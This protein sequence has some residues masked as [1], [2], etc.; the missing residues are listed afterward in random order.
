M[1][2][3]ITLIALLALIGSARA[4]QAPPAPQPP[5]AEPIVVPKG[6]VMQGIDLEAFLEMY[7]DL[8]GKTIITAQNLPKVTFSFRT[9]NDFTKREA[10]TF[11]ETLLSTRGI[12]IVPMNS[13]VVHA[14]PSSEVTKTPPAISVLRP[15]E[16]PEGDVYIH[17]V[18][19]LKHLKAADTVDLLLSLAKSPQS[20]TAIEGSE[21]LVL[22]D[23]SNNVRAMLAMLDE[24][25]VEAINDQE[26]AVV[27]IKYA[28]SADIA[29]VISSYTA[30]PTSRSPTAN[31][32]PGSTGTTSRGGTTS[33]TGSNRFDSSLQP[34]IAN[35]QG[36][37]SRGGLQ[38]RLSQVVQGAAFSGTGAAI[39]G[40]T[41]IVS[42][43]RGNEVIIVGNPAQVLQAM[44]LIEKLDRV[45][46]QVLIEA[47]IM[48]VALGDDSTFGVSIRQ[49]QQG[50]VGGGRSKFSSAL[51]SAMGPAAF[52]ENSVGGANSGFQ[53][54]NTFGLK[55]EVAI[56]AINN[57]TR[58]Q[59]LSTP[60]IQ[61]TH[62]SLAELFIGDTRPVVTGS[63][64][65]INGG[66]SSQY[67]MQKIGITLEVLPFI[68]DEGVVS[69]EINQQVQDIVGSQIIDGNSVPI[70]TDRSANAKV[71][72]RDGEMVV[73]GGFIKTK[74]T[75]TE[76]K[77]PVLGDF[78]L[79][80]PLFRRTVD[81]NERSE[82][83]MMMRP[84]VLATPEAAYAK[85][86]SEVSNKPGFE[87]AQFS[88]RFLS[89]KYRIDL[90]EVRERKKKVLLQRTGIDLDKPE[91][92]SL[93]QPT[94]ERNL[95]ELLKRPRR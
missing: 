78:P 93:P 48:D 42:W 17:Y 81:V 76:S 10:I 55:W 72:V 61:T 83:I 94:R 19:T 16:L 7:S 64:Q 4:Q 15:D 26:I 38:Q 77:V 46:P 67:Q 34:A 33:R 14:L 49:Q 60:R 37:S 12:A 36:S 54:W 91:E 39:L 68:N 13:K 79:L 65:D 56:E 89:N 70:T 25:D 88:E 1:K 29:Q 58:V 45:Q 35:T 90:E 20:V 62:A 11:Y 80:G 50:I 44:A 57:D 73:L 5:E 63:I 6:E 2:N 21:K 28:L 30:S 84:T 52:A 71:N 86:L 47:I 41:S 8:V 59:I 75:A 74:V 95:E 53:W 51:A 85:A 9:K 66:T 3:T 40:E 31:T 32:R 23:F 27:K 82:L 69:M 87:A 92:D 24:I 43:D 22:R 18:H